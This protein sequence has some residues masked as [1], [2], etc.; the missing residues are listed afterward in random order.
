MENLCSE[1]LKGSQNAQGVLYPDVTGLN[2]E[3]VRWF[4]SGLGLFEKMLDKISA[5]LADLHP[6]TQHQGLLHAD[7]CCCREEKDTEQGQRGPQKNSIT[8]ETHSISPLSLTHASRN[9]WEATSNF[10]LLNPWK[11]NKCILYQVTK[12]VIHL[13]RGCNI[14]PL[15]EKEPH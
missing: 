6:R 1:E 9:T 4:L 10:F 13:A 14:C 8:S 12:D 3:V 2:T 15:V 7:R 5:Q 11:N